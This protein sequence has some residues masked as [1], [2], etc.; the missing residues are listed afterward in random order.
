LTT[1]LS[2]KGQIILPKAIRGSRHWD[3]GTR[4]IVEHLDDSILP[5]TASIFPPTQPEDAFASLP[6]KG[7]P[8]TLAKLEAGIMVAARRRHARGRY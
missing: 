3:A 1:T 2:T 8:K 6:R 7:A 5:N 4:P